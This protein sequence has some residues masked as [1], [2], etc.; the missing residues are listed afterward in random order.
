M[1]RAFLYAS[2]ALTV[3]ILFTA[4]SVQAA[5]YATGYSPFYTLATEPGNITGVDDQKVC[6]LGVAIDPTGY[7]LALLDNFTWGAG[8]DIAIYGLNVDL[9]TEEYEVRIGRYF[10]EGIPM[11]VSEVLWTAYDSDG[12]QYIGIGEPTGNWNAI[13]LDATTGS[14]GLWPG[15]EIDAVYARYP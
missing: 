7:I 14:G 8:W 12:T 10:G 5:G 1:K 13:R 2:I 6:S 15:P 9:S 11:V 3:L 4:N